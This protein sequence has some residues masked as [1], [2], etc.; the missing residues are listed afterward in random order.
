MTAVPWFENALAA[1]FSDQ[2]HFKKTFRHSRGM[3]P[4]EYRWRLRS[5]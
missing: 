5:R 3:T 2:S 4:D 1:G